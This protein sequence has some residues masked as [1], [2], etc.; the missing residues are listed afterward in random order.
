M[1]RSSSAR[2]ISFNKNNMPKK[3]RKDK[4]IAE[5]RR[6]IRESHSSSGNQSVA[7]KVQIKPTQTASSGYQLQHF[8]N[9]ISTTNTSELAEYTAI[10][11]D[12]LK[13]VLLA[14]SALVAELILFWK[15]R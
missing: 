8:D 1:L 13:T 5:A 7:E 6:I 14:V 15:F 11:K 4:I 12:L 3:T 9:S 2:L 10:K